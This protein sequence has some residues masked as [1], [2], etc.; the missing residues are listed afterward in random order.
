L[1]NKVGELSGEILAGNSEEDSN[2]I[3]FDLD[4]SLVSIDQTE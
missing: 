1:S 3:K 4:P 2:F